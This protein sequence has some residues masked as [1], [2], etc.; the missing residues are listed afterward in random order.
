MARI[1]RMTLAASLW[2]LVSVVHDAE[3]TKEG[4]S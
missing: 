3:I 1:A 2:C 4:P